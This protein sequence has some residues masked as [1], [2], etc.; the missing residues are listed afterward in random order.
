MPGKG[1]GDL[2]NLFSSDLNSCGPSLPLPHPFPLGGFFTSLLDSPFGVFEVRGVKTTRSVLPS[3][4]C[5][6]VGGEESVSVPSEENF[7]V[8]VSFFWIYVVVP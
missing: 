7:L 2:C 8:G 5:G 6:V 4:V 1:G 3:S